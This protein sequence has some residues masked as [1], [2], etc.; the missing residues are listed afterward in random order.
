MRNRTGSHTLQRAIQ[1]VRPSQT[2]APVGIGGRPDPTNPGSCH[3]KTNVSAQSKRWWGEKVPVV[4]NR[5]DSDGGTFGNG[6][7]GVYPPGSSNDRF[8]ERQDVI[9]SG[10]AHYFYSDRVNPQNFLWGNE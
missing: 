5:R 7:F 1:L 9:F 2:T 10:R 6:Q 3:E 8:R 4:S